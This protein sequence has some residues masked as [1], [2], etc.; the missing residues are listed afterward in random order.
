MSAQILLFEQ[1]QKI[2]ILLTK[3]IT[4]ILQI[5]NG[6]RCF[7]YIFERQNTEEKPQLRF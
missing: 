4:L 6:L 5:V 1:V 2:V 7:E 3:L